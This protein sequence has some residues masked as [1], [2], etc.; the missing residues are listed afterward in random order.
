[1]MTNDALANRTRR[2]QR[3][4]FVALG[5]GSALGLVMIAVAWFVI[6]RNPPAPIVIPIEGGM[7]RT[8]IPGV[9][10]LEG[11]APGERSETGFLGSTEPT[12]AKPPG[13]FRVVVVGDS[14]STPPH[15]EP[16][17]AFPN[18]AAGLV[19]A[20]DRFGEVEVLNLSYSGMSFRQE[21]ALIEHRVMPFD[22]DLLVISFCYND[23]VETFIMAEENA[24]EDSEQFLEAVHDRHR[25][26]DPDA[27]YLDRFRESLGRL[28][29]V[30]GDVP[31]L[32]VAPP[33]RPTPGAPAENYLEV[34]TPI[35]EEAGYP[36]LDLRD[37]LSA[38]LSTSDYRSNDD[39]HFLLSGHQKVAAALVEAL[40]EHLPAAD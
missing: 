27:P 40:A 18:V 30:R 13:T 12:R 8:D 25:W 9:P 17:G 3:A 21:V 20:D 34:I 35:V 19:A 16:D 36:M 15:G 31:V 39:I 2:S 28:D 37:A 1:M 23:L 10:I 38:P 26:Y 33:R 32:F 24:W 6:D 11:P 29:A 7:V 14:V 4:K 22:P 5:V